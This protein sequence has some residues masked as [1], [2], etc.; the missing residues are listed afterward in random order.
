MTTLSRRS[1]IGMGATLA[2]GWQ[3]SALAHRQFA[4]PEAATLAL[5]PG[6]PAALGAPD[7][8]TPEAST[9]ADA[10]PMAAQIDPYADY[11]TDAAIGEWPRT[12]R[13][14]MGETVIESPPQRVITLDPGELDAAIQLGIVPVGSAEYAAYSL[15]DY[16]LEAVGDM[17]L[18][19]T[20]QEP[21]LEAIIA[22]QPDLILSTKLRHETLYETLSSIAPTVFGLRPGTPFK[23]NVKLYAQTTGT[24]EAT[25][26]LV[27]R[28]E[29]RVREVNAGLP[30]PRPSM[31]IVQ[32]RPD[33]IRFYQTA[34]F[35][36]VLLRDLGFPRGSENVDN[37]AIDE[38]AELLG[39]QADGEYIILTVQNPEENDLAP[40][41]VQGEI[42]SQLP[43]VQAG[44][45]LEVDS[46]VWIGGVGYGAA[47][48]VL[49][50][51]AEFFAS[52][53]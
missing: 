43:A 34:N 37:F 39:E 10:V 47:F 36:G 26:D 53:G 5:L 7:V 21:D 35:L 19:G 42:W 16:V 33:F 28:Y 52:Q 46:A 27:R 50:E 2:V 15:T 18:V 29:D 45:V 49:D 32:I 23:E 30:L 51:M 9:A 13:H 11:G 38:S 6:D 17:P 40:E 3:V 8:P 48:E 20:T 14:A 25:A 4:S 1:A 41:V 31:S 24:E 12:I 44:K 22:L